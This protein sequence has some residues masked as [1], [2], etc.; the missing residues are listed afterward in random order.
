MDS[1]LAQTFDRFEVVVV[2]DGSTDQSARILEPY[3]SN[4]RVRYYSK[5]NGGVASARNYGIR[6]A[7]GRFIAFCDQDDIWLKEKL[8]RQ[9]PLFD[10]QEVGL[11]YCWLAMA[12]WR[13]DGTLVD[14]ANSADPPRYSGR[15]IEPLFSKNFIACS[16][17]VFRKSLLDQV[18]L[19]CENP[20]LRGVDDW[21]L[22]LRLA[23]ISEVAFVPE[24]MV[25]YGLHGNNYSRNER[26]MFAAER[27][28]I[29]DL[30][31]FL[32]SHGLTAESVR[33]TQH[34][35]A[36]EYTR[37]LINCGDYSAAARAALEAWSL[38]PKDVSHLLLAAGLFALPS[39]A[40]TGGRDSLRSLRTFL[41]KSR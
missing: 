9:I 20:T 12:T 13:E 33:R 5:K 34:R 15:C 28:C 29:R 16:T 19:L 14:L 30:A 26:L 39:R 25:R 7:K 2:N 31:D 18:G 4:R 38:R 21:H 24:H 35:S 27:Y 11:V 23:S 6:R 8:C 40:I 37:N 32:R 41:A 1:I 10:Q 3:C 17:A 22:W 36:A